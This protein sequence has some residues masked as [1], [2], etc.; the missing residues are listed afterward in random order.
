MNLLS[1]LGISL[2][3]AVIAA[4]LTTLMT[5]GTWFDLRL[6]I[7]FFFATAG[8][9][10]LVGS[11]A[12]T[13]PA[14]SNTARHYDDTPGD[15]ALATGDRVQGEVKWFNTAKGFGF[16]RQDDGD[17][18]FVHFRSIRGSGRRG[19]RDGQRVSFIIAQSDK[20]P[21]AEDVEALA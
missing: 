11:P 1:R 19:L 12:A 10:I 13:E 3:V 8:T 14:P 7:A 17:E 18:I 4:T 16:I 6:L 9:T 5:T 15:T 20:G 21:Q 2:L